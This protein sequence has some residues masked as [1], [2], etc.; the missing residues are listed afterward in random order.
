VVRRK[1]IWRHHRRHVVPYRTRVCYW[2]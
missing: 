2:R 1:V